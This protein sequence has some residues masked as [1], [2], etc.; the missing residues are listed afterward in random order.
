MSRIALQGCRLLAV[1]PNWE[2]LADDP[3]GKLSTLARI[4]DKQADR[5]VVVAAAL[6]P[7]ALHEQAVGQLIA[8]FEHAPNLRRLDTMMAALRFLTGRDFQENPVRWRDWWEDR[9]MSSL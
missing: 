6:L 8:D 1:P 3:L 4:A 5:H 7:R 2:P 9:K